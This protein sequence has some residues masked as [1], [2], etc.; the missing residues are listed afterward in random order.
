MSTENKSEITFHMGLEF[1]A[2]GHV[3]NIL[4]RNLPI[5]DELRH[6][7]IDL[8]HTSA[9]LVEDVNDRQG[10]RKADTLYELPLI[11]LSGVDPK[12]CRM[13]IKP[14]LKNKLIRELECTN[15]D[16][17]EDELVQHNQFTNA[18]TNYPLAWQFF[19]HNEFAHSVDIHPLLKITKEM[20][21]CA[22]RTYVDNKM[23]AIGKYM[24]KCWKFQM[25]KKVWYKIKPLR[26]CKFCH[27]LFRSDL[28]GFNHA[29]T[30]DHLRSMKSFIES[31]HPICEDISILIVQYTGINY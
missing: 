30:D 12:E 13:E 16:I 8:T 4:V 9:M 28:D 5:E 21:I 1:Y 31:L 11:E 27:K 7:S 23:K 6:V 22:G 18:F 29:V 17:I 15:W 19:F 10:D 20:A 25:Y 3:N 2:G 26:K 14:N 24:Y